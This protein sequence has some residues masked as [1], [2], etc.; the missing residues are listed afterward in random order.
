MQHI[1]DG[2]APPEMELHHPKLSQLITKH[3]KRSFR[4]ISRCGEYIAVRRSARLNA[5]FDDFRY[6]TRTYLRFA[7]ALEHPEVS[8]H[9]MRWLVSI[10]FLARVR[11]LLDRLG[12]FI[13]ANIKAFI[14]A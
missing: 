12:A 7:F 11:L 5:F 9:G 10:V 6:L 4:E 8:L 13:R 1:L 3:V 2:G 14:R